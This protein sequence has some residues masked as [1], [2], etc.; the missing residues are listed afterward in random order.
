MTSTTSV[1]AI[2][3]LRRRMIEDMRVRKFGEKTQHDYISHVETF[4]RF[5]G[6]SPET[7]TAEDLRR[8]PVHQTER[9]VQP[10]TVTGSVVAMRFLFT[11]TLGRANLAPS[12]HACI[13][14]AG[15]CVS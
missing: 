5:L 15:C 3:P 2:S 7:A 14:R 1:E 9:G 10:P 8:Y 4:A 12:S 6:R 13:T 11:I